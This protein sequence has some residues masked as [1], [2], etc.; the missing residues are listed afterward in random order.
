MK[1]W[2][3]PTKD[4]KKLMNAITKIFCEWISYF[5][6]PKFQTVR[7]FEFV[8]HAYW[9]FSGPYYKFEEKLEMAGKAS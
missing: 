9:Y 6:H 4:A 2:T 3:Q 5:T 7:L 8:S 1:V